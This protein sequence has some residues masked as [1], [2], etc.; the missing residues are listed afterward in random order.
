MS[1]LWQFALIG[2]AGGGAYAL[3]ALGVVAVYRGSGVLNFAQ[4]AIGMVGS[5]VFWDLHAGSEGGAGLYGGTTSS[6]AVASLPVAPAMLIGVASG[7]VLGLLFYLLV[8][9]LLRNVPDMAKVVATLGLMLL[10]Q[11]AVVKRYGTESHLLPPL[12]GRGKIKI[13]GGLVTYDTLAILVVTIGLAVGLSLMFSRTK[14]GMNATALRENPTAASGI[15]I[16][17]HPTG[18]ITWGVGGAMAAFAGI[19]LIPVI[20]LTPDA[21]TLLV[22]PAM[23]AALVGRFNAVWTTVAIGLALGVAESVMRRYS[24]NNGVISSVP[25]AV[26]IVT[27]V[28]GGAAMPGRGEALS[29]RLPRAGSGRLRPVTGLVWV[30]AAVAIPLFAAPSWSAAMTNSALFGLLGL[31]VVVVTGYA[32]QISVACAALAGFGSFA[33]ARASS[34][35]HL[36]FLVCLI[37][38]TA[39][40]VLLGVVF[41]APAV[42]VRGV[43]LAIVTLGLSLAVENLVLSQ[44]KMT[45]GLDGLHIHR[46][47]LFGLDLSPSAHPDRFAYVCIAAFVLCGLAVLNLRRGEAGRRLL[48]VRANERGAAAL[49]VSVPGTKLGAFAISAGIAGL[50]GALSAFQFQLADFTDFGVF[51]SISVLAFTVVGG[52]GFV[53]GAVFAATT[54][55]GGVVATAISDLL[56]VDSIDA[57]LSIATGLVVLDAM[58]RS[59][60]G[61]VPAQAALKDAVVRLVARAARRGPAPAAGDGGHAGAAAATAGGPVSFEPSCPVPAGETV[62]VARDIRVTYGTAVAVDGVSFELA[63]GRVVG[64]IGPNGAGK[65]SLIDAVTGFTRT[66][67]GSVELLGRDISALRAPARA[68]HGL[69]R[70]FQ[71]L[72]LFDDLSVRENVLTGLD[73]R[74]PLAYVRDLFWPR[75]GV[76]S[77]AAAAAVTLLGLD[78]VLDTVVADLPQGRRRMV[79]IARLVAQRPAAVLLDEPAAGLNGSER[80]T[81]SELFRLLARQSGA[82][83]LLVEHNIDVVAATCDHV[84]V[85]DFGRVIASGSPDEVLCDPAVRAAYLGKLSGE[86]QGEPAAEPEPAAETVVEA[87][88]PIAPVAG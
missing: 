52:V 83:V 7:A 71:N 64:V 32:G 11:S 76:L 73:G 3:V 46:P 37:V 78:D 77:D 47:N 14:L 43:N 8:V 82:A 25:F 36:P 57:W 1:Q 66:S 45:G 69:G 74:G 55:V 62:L 86:A 12:F 24:I 51:R 34:D 44:P 20:G 79:A 2:L 13:L 59:P 26:I 72:E 67:G 22:I 18:L 6:G 65:T 75:R 81:A 68:R 85:L 88:G 23:A 4:G 70:T 87:G 29:G 28:L 27:V 61:I 21:L 80:R 58:V 16:S 40:A 56:S 35:L 9:R 17:P 63:A 84:V 5:Y 41:G 60:S 49:G 30:L 39:A 42:R 38:G 50:A 53:A 33:A 31:S 15:G 54:A 10:L 48:A 19:L